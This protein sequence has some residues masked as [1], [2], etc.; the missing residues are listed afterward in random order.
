M[1]NARE[2]TKEQLRQYDPVNNP[3]NDVTKVKNVNELFHNNISPYKFIVANTDAISQPEPDVYERPAE[4]LKEPH[5]NRWIEMSGYWFQ[6]NKFLHPR[7]RKNEW[8]HKNNY[9]GP[10]P[11][12]NSSPMTN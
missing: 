1:T 3:Y 12:G 5:R 4:F 8:M 6:K 7:L 10:I 9:E 11:Q 2:K